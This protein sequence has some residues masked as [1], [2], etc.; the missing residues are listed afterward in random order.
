MKK[1]TVALL[2]VVSMLM[3]LCAGC[4]SSDAPAASV[5]ATMAPTAE[6]TSPPEL[7]A[8]PEPT[9]EPVEETAEPAKEEEEPAEEEE[10]PV[11]E[12]PA[13]STGAN[14]GNN[15][16]SN[17]QPEKEEKPEPTAEPEPEVDKYEVASGMTGSPVS[18]LYAAIGEPNG[19]EYT[20]SCLMPTGEDGL[21]YYDDFTVSTIKYP[22]GTE[23]VMGVF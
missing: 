7:T 15:S 11:E 22:D 4:G 1:I 2:L 16:N 6:P 3:V 20:A 10:E 21:L 8:E 23:L 19:S 5:S 17:S 13:Q 18:D 9:A 14:S 12:K